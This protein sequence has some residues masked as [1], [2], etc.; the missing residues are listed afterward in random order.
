MARPMRTPIG[1][2]RHRVTVQRATEERDSYGQPVQTWSDIGRVWARIRP[3]SG[4]EYIAAR[5]VQADL[6]HEVT[7]RPFDGLTPKDRLEFTRNNSTRVL[8]I[9]SIADDEE[10]GRFVIL[11]CI[12]EVMA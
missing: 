3:L 12:E 8:N 4:R 1:K 2:L 5:Q 10:R 9:D 7:I 6:T 11:R